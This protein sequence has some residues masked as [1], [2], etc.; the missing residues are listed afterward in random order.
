MKTTWALEGRGV[1]SATVA[2]VDGATGAVTAALRDVYGP[3]GPD[4]LASVLTNVW[5]PL[6]HRLVTE[7]ETAVRNG[8]EWSATLSGISVTLSP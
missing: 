7:G 5:G 4:V 1:G 2:D 3:D 6:R 8:R